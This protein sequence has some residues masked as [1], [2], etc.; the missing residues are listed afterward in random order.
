M[1]ESSITGPLKPSKNRH[2]CIYLRS[3]FYITV[4]AIRLPRV[5]QADSHRLPAARTDV[6]ISD[7]NRVLRILLHPHKNNPI[8]LPSPIL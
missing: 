8:A 4:R 6:R 1:M 7:A 2:A 3:P 5:A